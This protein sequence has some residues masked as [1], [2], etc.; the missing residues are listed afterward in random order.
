MCVLCCYIIYCHQ[1]G[2]L[3]MFLVAYACV[4]QE[5]YV[6]RRPTVIDEGLSWLGFLL[7]I[8]WYSQ[9][10]RLHGWKT[11][12]L[13][14][15]LI[16]PW[17]K[18][19]P[20]FRVSYHLLPHDQLITKPLTVHPVFLT[21]P[22]SDILCLWSPNASL[23]DSRDADRPLQISSY[24]KTCWSM[25]LFTAAIPSASTPLLWL[26]GKGWRPVLELWMCT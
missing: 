1:Y 15:L 20:I 21:L 18:A 14:P 4:G 22:I 10:C 8:A 26:P 3:I 13:T 24:L 5:G 16:V 25:T 7:K 2:N 6:L 17:S 23:K 12:A 9:R 11:K 19:L